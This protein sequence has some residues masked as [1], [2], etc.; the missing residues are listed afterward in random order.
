MNIFRYVLA[1]LPEKWQKKL[2]VY[3]VSSGKIFTTPIWKMLFQTLSFYG[4]DEQ[5]IK[6]TL[7]RKHDGV[8][9]VYMEARRKGVI[10]WGGFSLFAAGFCFVVSKSNPVRRG[11]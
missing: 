3:L 5:K 10:K 2:T 9:S 1:K 11:E 7:V 4:G 6:K 8:E